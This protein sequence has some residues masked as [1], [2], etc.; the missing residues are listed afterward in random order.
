MEKVELTA[1]VYRVTKC[2]SN[3][4]VELNHKVSLLSNSIV[5]IF[6]LLRDPCSEVV[7]SKRIDHV[8]QPLARKLGYIS[9]VR[10]V[11]FDLL[12]LAAI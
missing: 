10:Q 5:S 6:N 8:D 11:L 12:D 9:L 1:D 2:G 3:I 4:R 7:A